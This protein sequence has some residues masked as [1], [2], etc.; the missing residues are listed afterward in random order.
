VIVG[1][2]L[3]DLRLARALGATSIA[4][5]WGY[6]SPVVLADEGPA[7]VARSFEEAISIIRGAPRG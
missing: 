7:F 6:V 2:G 4:A 5:A 3:P 1:D